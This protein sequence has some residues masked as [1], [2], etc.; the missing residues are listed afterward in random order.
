MTAKRDPQPFE[1]GVVD[2]PRAI[3]AADRPFEFR[4]PWLTTRE[5][6]D[7]LRYRG[8]H[9]LR[10]LYRFLKANGIP[11]RHRSPRCLLIA[12]ADLDRALAPEKRVVHVLK[13]KAS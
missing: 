3:D 2:A 6:A 4:G 7:Y 12:K 5:A 10:S 1:P 13:H 8:K 11:I 9:A